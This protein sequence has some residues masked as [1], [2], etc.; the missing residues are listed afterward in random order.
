MTPLP[1][2]RAALVLA[3]LALLEGA[4]DASS[5]PADA[6]SGIH[7]INGVR[8]ATSTMYHCFF[9]ESQRAP[10]AFAASFS[11]KGVTRLILIETRLSLP[12]GSITV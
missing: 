12:S 11:A 4:V 1:A 10:S 7:R 5:L 8:S 6:K 9:A 2:E 3:G